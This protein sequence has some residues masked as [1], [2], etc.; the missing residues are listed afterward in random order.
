MVTIGIGTAGCKIVNSFS[1]GHKKILIGPDKF[2]KT[3]K[4]VEDYEN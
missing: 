2:P 4:T 1:K 3:C